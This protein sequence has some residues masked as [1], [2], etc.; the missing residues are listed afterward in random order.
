MT[1]EDQQFLKEI[2]LQWPP[3]DRVAAQLK[4]PDDLPARIADSDEHFQPVRSTT[5]QRRTAIR[6]SR[7]RTG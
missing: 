2:G 7:I 6:S 1:P 3:P 4:L 5:T